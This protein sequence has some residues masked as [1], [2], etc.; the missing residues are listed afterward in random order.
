[1]Q[2]A[3]P[4]LH[5]WL[6]RGQSCSCNRLV[7]V[8]ERK[9]ETRAL[10]SLY[11]R[12]GG[13]RVPPQGRTITVNR[14]TAYATTSGLALPKQPA[15]PAPEVCAPLPALVV[16]DL[17]DRDGRSPHA[18]LFGPRDLVVITGLPGSGKST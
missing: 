8:S 12:R 15:V 17:R 14:T 10:P 4:S 16:R 11:T 3:P 5:A 13:T 6:I 2:L 7:A 1:M 9:R 18:L